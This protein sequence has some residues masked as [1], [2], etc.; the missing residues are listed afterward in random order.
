MKSGIVVFVGNPFNPFEREQNQATARVNQIVE[1]V[2]R[3]YGVDLFKNTR[4]REIVFPRQVAMLM[5]LANRSNIGVVKIGELFGRHHASVI[6]AVKTINDLCESSHEIKKQ[7]L[8]IQ[9]LLQ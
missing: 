5:L 4:K 3:Y 8:E 7:I 2:G 6:Y 9:R 1:I